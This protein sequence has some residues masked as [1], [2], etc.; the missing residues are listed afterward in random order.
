MLTRRA[1]EICIPWGAEFTTNTMELRGCSKG[2]IAS[3]SE[4]LRRCVGMK[5]WSVNGV[6][7][8]SPK[9]VAAISEESWVI[10]FRF[11]PATDIPG[12]SVIVDKQ[13]EEPSKT[14]TSL[15][16]LLRQLGLEAFE[17]VLHDAGLLDMADLALIASPDDLPPMPRH[18]QEKLAAAVLEMGFEA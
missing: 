14:S 6:P 2:S 16:N 7:V 10:E 5:L 13:Q 15:R 9:D 11:L 18:A 3:K 8:S 1:F 12:S 4:E 17:S